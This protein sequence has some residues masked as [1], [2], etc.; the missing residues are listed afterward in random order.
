MKSGPKGS[1]ERNG[2][3][4]ALLQQIAQRHLSIPTLEYRNS[5]RLDF[6]EVGVG[7]L[8]SALMAAYEAGRA[9]VTSDP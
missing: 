1:E 2:N 9:S 6:H 7:R 5:D 8:K 3:L 4:E